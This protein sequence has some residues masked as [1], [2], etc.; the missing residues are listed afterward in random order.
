MMYVCGRMPLSGNLVSCSLRTLAIFK[1]LMLCTSKRS[2]R[3]RREKTKFGK[4]RFY[5][6]EGERLKRK[7][8]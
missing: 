6:G 2:S 3:F 4:I 1:L 8:K 7:E 5:D